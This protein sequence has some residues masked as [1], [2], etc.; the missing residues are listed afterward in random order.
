MFCKQSLLLLRRGGKKKKVAIEA[1]N[2]YEKES[3]EKCKSKYKE[4]KSK[5]KGSFWLPSWWA[6]HRSTAKQ[7]QYFAHW[8]GTFSL[9]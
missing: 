8:A 1:T 3:L 9:K 2:N 7:G 5:Y 4:N 6:L